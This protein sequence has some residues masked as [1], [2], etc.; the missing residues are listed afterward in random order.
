MTDRELRKLRRQDLLQL[1][2]DQGREFERQRQQSREFEMNLIQSEATCER[3]KSRLDDKDSQIERLKGRLDKKDAQLRELREMLE[4]QQNFRRI[5]I[6]KAG[7]IAEAALKLNGIFEAAQRAADQY[8]M[9]VRQTG[10]ELDKEEAIRNAD[11]EKLRQ[12]AEEI[13]AQDLETETVSDT[14]GNIIERL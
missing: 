8:L 2:L 14:E 5:E 1:L 13:L 11:E 12:I 9:N 6:E 7:S 3:L 4:R 10:Q